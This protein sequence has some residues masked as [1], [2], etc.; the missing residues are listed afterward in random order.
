MI[1]YDP[2]YEF[3]D[4]VGLRAPKPG[5]PPPPPPGEC[6]QDFMWDPVSQ[7]C[8]PVLPWPIQ[9]NVSGDFGVPG[10][11]GG[12]EP[13]PDEAAYYWLHYGP[14]PGAGSGQYEAEVAQNA[15]QNLAF[16][17]G[18]LGE[19]YFASGDE[20]AGLDLGAIGSYGRQLGEKLGEWGTQ[21]G[22]A[23]GIS[24]GYGGGGFLGDA[25]AK[26]SVA[27]DAAKIAADEARSAMGQ[28][29][30]TAAHAR[31]SAKSVKEA[32]EVAKYAI[33]GLGILGGAALIYYI[34][35]D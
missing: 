30:E 29:G 17:V 12:Y 31:E 25:P 15:F 1:Y 19:T 5:P 22:Q 9:Q 26:A 14:P 16:P 10:E 27:A 21:A 3:A 2:H 8:V 28:L 18:N 11:F 4:F 13:R 7:S 33:I 35:K 24:H 34:A 32:A 20:Y 6:P 23:L